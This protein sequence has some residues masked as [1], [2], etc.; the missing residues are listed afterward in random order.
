[1]GS[2]LMWDYLSYAWQLLNG[3]RA[4]H[5]RAIATARQRDVAPYLDTDRP[6]RVLD[7]ANGRLRPQYMLLQ[8]T[9]HRVYGIDLANGPQRGWIDLAYR[10]ARRLYA[11]K[12]SVSPETAARRTLVCGDVGYL[13]FRDG[14]FDLVTSVAA[15]EHFL[16]VPRVVREL[17]RVVRPGGLVWVRIHLFT[18]PSGGH[19]TRFTEIP[20]R[21]L[22]TG[23]EPWDH[24]RQRRLPFPVPLNEWRRDQYL[25]AFARHFEILKHYCALREGEEWLTP[26]WRLSSLPTAGMNSPAALTS[27]WPAN[28]CDQPHIKPWNRKR[29]PSD[30]TTGC[31]GFRLLSPS[32]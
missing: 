3:F 7:L 14:S 26:G 29:A 20:L 22:P 25:E 5:E 27:S 31:G 12:L 21:T 28:R 10:V 18:S 4:R 16:H 2:T 11:W 15:F 30:D 1:M 13:P 9:G 23:I 24:L 17:A 32:A 19:N 8:A 6:L